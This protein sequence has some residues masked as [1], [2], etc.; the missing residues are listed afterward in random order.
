VL[1]LEGHRVV[2]PGEQHEPLIFMPRKMR[3]AGRALLEP[4]VVPISYPQMTIYAVLFSTQV[5]F[6]VGETERGYVT[7]PCARTTQRFLPLTLPHIPPPSW[8]L[9]ARALIVFKVG[10]SALLQCGTRP[11]FIECMTSA[12]SSGCTRRMTGA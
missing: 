1:T 4:F 12:G 7:Y 11:H 8:R 3:D 2:Q 9:S 6:T 10:G 5:P